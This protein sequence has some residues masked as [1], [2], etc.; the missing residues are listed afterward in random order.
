MLLSMTDGRLFSRGD[1][2][3]RLLEL[4]ILLFI[5]DVGVRRIQ[6]E[7][8]EL[9][10]GWRAVQRRVFFWQ[11]FRA[12][13]IGRILAALLARERRCDPH[14]RAPA[15]PKADCSDRR[16]QS[17]SPCL[18]CR[19]RRLRRSPRRLHQARSQRKEPAEP[20]ATRPASVLEAKRRAQKAQAVIRPEACEY[21]S[22]QCKNL[23]PKQAELW[24]YPPVRTGGEVIF[25]RGSNLLWHIGANKCCEARCECRF[26][27]L[28]QCKGVG[29]R[30]SV[31]RSPAD[32]KSPATVRNLADGR[33][34]LLAEGGKD[35]LEAFRKGI[36]DSGPGAFPSEGR[37]EL[38]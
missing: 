34:E 23:L 20:A 12:A 21:A 3:E 33:V 28:A 14:K 2:W 16:N 17:Q 6:L 35:E 1:L 8:D 24:L 29:F 37:C 5:V 22:P 32:T 26:Y 18:V 13:G 10:R 30:Y 38:G 7:R 11:E 19:V 9:L 36:R 25:Y 4:A 27:I 15:E 31:N